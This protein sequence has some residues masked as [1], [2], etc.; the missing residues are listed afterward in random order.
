MSLSLSCKNRIKFVD[1]MEDGFGESVEQGLPRPFNSGL[2]LLG[3]ILQ[4]LN[5]DVGNLSPEYFTF[6]V[7]AFNCVG[8]AIYISTTERFVFRRLEVGRSA[9]LCARVS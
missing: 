8:A 6:L 2:V 5:E 1:V 3:H 4:L 9:F 7:S